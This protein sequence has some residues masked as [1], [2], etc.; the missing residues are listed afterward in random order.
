MATKTQMTPKELATK[1]VGSD[2]AEKFA[3]TFIRPYLRK[4][5]ARN[6]EQRGTSWTLTEEQVKAVTDAYKARQA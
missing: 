1:L 3:K 5:F 4:H 2:D 6:D